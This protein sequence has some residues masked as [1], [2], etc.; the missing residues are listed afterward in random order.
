MGMNP[1]VLMQLI[2]GLGS[3]QGL[4]MGLSQLM[5]PGG[6]GGPGYSLT[7]GQP[8]SQLMQPQPGQ[9]QMYAGGN[10]TFSETGSSLGL[11]TTLGGGMGGIPGQYQLGAMSPNQG[12][13]PPGMP[14]PGG[15]DSFM[16]QAARMLSQGSPNP[17]GTS[18]L[19]PKPSY[20]AADYKNEGRARF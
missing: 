4:G 11:P 10:P 18:G 20:N 19:A 9:Q 8:P 14:M 17:S 5:Q 13:Q 6:M 12:F 2:G 7:G 15:M 3:G 16:A 1:Q